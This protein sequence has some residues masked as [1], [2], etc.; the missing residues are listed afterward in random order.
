MR[1]ILDLIVIDN[2]LESL[3]LR[4]ALEYW[5]VKVNL[6]LIGKPQDFVDLLAGGNLS[7]CVFIS[8]HGDDKGFLFQELAE[9]VAKG[10]PFNEI[11]DSEKLSSFLRL[12]NNIVVS[13]ACKT[14]VDE[15]GNIFLSK[16]AK[17]FIAPEDYPEGDASLIF[18][19]NFYYWLFVK[20]LNVEEAFE[21][22]KNMDSET[23]MFQL[24]K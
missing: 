17:Y 24:F 16:G 14:G 19:V 6:Y 21:K 10:Q 13:N 12:D 11:L 7:K 1:K 18:A 5:G 2:D 8:S 20:N 15:F 9:E 23:S 4:S 3:A 22:A